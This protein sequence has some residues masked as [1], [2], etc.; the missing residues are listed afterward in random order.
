MDLPVLWTPLVTW[1]TAKYIAY[2]HISILRKEVLYYNTK[3]IADGV[4]WR[5]GIDGHPQA[6]PESIAYWVNRRGQGGAFAKLSIEK[7]V[8]L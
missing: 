3:G 5:D 7:C 8:T 1:C 4:V 2:S 6:Q